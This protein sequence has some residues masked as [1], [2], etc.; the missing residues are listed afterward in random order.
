M[1]TFEQRLAYLA[2]AV[3]ALDGGDEIARGLL[4][5]ASDMESYLERHRTYR[6]R[7]AWDI[8]EK[9]NAFVNASI[10]DAHRSC[11]ARLD[12]ERRRLAQRVAADPRWQGGYADTLKLLEI[13]DSR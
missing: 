13:A 12:H 8:F 3:R 11:D 2:D 1:A 10:A 7:Q 9:W 6:D 4:R 5:L